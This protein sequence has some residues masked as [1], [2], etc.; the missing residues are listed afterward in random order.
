MNQED[1]EL[2]KKATIDLI[3]KMGFKGEIKIEKLTDSLI[4]D[5][6]ETNPL[7][8]TWLVNIQTKE[9]SNILIGRHG[10]NLDAL[11]HLTRLMARHK[12]QEPTHFILDVN[13]YKKQRIEFL[14]EL[15]S[16]VADQVK[17]NKRVQS[18]QPMPAYERRII[19]L[20]LSSKKG[21]ATESLGREPGRKVI[22]KPC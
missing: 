9:D 7:P 16:R 1:I 22:V 21:I 11:Q 12:I 15:A 8:E 19:H 18:L 14:K 3:E 20:E 2:L 13:D 6:Q 10:S 5:E 4:Q 17:R